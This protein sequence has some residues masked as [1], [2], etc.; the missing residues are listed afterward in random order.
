MESQNPSNLTR[1]EKTV[2]NRGKADRLRK[3]WGIQVAQGRYR[4]T[5]NWY[6]ALTRFPAA[7]FD[8]NGY[9]IFETEVLHEQD[10][11]TLLFFARIVIAWCI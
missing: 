8:A 6:S 3:T 7:L 11:K 10:W 1:R 5:G 2:L 4:E 9:I